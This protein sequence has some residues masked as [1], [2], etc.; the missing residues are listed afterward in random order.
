MWLIRAQDEVLV[1][2][3]S[4]SYPRYAILS[5]V[6][7]R[8]EVSFQD[9]Q[10][11]ARASS[12]DN[13]TKIRQTC[14]RALADGLSYVWVDTCCINKENYTELIEAINSMYSWY[15]AADICYALLS[16]VHG[17][18]LCSQTI[19]EIKES[20]WF[21][22]GWTLQELIAPDKVILFNKYWQTLGT[23]ESLAEVLTSRTGVPAG[24]LNKTQE[25]SSQS[26]A[27]R[28]S[29]ASERV[30]TREE[31]WAYCLLGIFDVNMPLFYGEGER[32]A[33]LRLQEEIIRKSDDHSIFAWDIHALQ[34]PSK[35]SDGGAVATSSARI[36]QQLEF[37]HG[38]LAPSPK[39]FGQ[40]QNVRETTSRRGRT[41]Y[42]MTNR[43]LSIS[44]AALLVS[45]DTYLVRL[46]CDDTSMKRIGKAGDDES[47]LCIFLTRLHDDDQYARTVS[48][49]GESYI[50]TA[51]WMQAQKGFDGRYAMIIDINVR[52]P[53]TSVSNLAESKQSTLRYKRL[54]SGFRLAQPQLYEWGSSNTCWWDDNDRIMEM[55]PIARFG[56]GAVLYIKGKESK[57]KIK[58]IKLGIDFEC[59]PVCLVA[60]KTGLSS[61]PQ[62][63][64][65]E[66]YNAAER[67]SFLSLSSRDVFGPMTLCNMS[68]SKTIR[69]VSVLWKLWTYYTALILSVEQ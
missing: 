14:T 25:L 50:R 33:F 63:A 30:T 22:R 27:Q 32:K 29:W 16:D 62:V 36:V 13:F 23:K 7:G 2:A 49:K 57:V 24:I 5:H 48:V 44:F 19:H 21:T 12:M 34:K 15:Q 69:V 8:H 56:Q 35:L 45:M 17:E 41:A 47:C 59:N 68:G 54:V 46:Y 11:P 58:A 61:D 51:D 37:L 66:T 20:K 40:C 1:D 53:T 64:N 9:M 3:R 55:K 6:W 39:A 38:L 10:D 60:T 43:G 65:A 52:Q 42:T 4:E 26:I 67:L 18:P 28:M 31:D